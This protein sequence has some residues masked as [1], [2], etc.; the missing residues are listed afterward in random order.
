VR[1]GTERVDAAL[2][3][4]RIAVLPGQQHIAMDLDAERFVREVVGFL[5]G[6]A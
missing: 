2:P 1:E 5:L 3:D 6:P 4:S